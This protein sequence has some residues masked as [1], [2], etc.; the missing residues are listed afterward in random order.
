MISKEDQELHGLVL[1]YID[2]G[3]RPMGGS[4]LNYNNVDILIINI[5]ELS[6][7]N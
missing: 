6:E 1:G 5:F 3:V 7:K 2:K 4:F